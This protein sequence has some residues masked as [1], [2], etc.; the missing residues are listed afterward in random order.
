MPKKQTMVPFG[1][2]PECQARE[3]LFGT[4]SLKEIRKTPIPTWKWA[5]IFFGGA[6]VFFLICW[7]LLATSGEGLSYVYR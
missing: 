7:L 6:T 4:P 1:L 3:G 5:A 2:P